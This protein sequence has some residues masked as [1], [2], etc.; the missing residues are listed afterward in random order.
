MATTVGNYPANS[1]STPQDGDPLSASVVVNHFNSTR[2][3]HTSHDADPGIHL[4]SSTLASRPAASTAGRKWLTADAGEYKLWYDD[5]VKWHEVGGAVI[6]LEYIASGA[7][8]KGD[9]LKLSGWN[10]GLDLPILTPATAASDVVFAIATGN[11]ANGASGYAINTG[12]IEDVN[13]SAFTVGDRLYPSGTS[14]PGSISSWFTTTKP[15]SGE[16]QMCAYVIRDNP[17]NGVLFV[18][19]SASAIVESSTNVAN[20]VVRRDGSGNFAA[21]T[22]TANLIGNVTGNVTGSAGSAASLTTPRTLWGQSFNGTANV[23]GAISGATSISATGN[24]TVGGALT[25]TG[26]NVSIN[27]VPYAFPSSAGTSGYVLKTDGAGNLTWDSVAVGAIA[28]NDLSDVT[29]TGN[30]VLQNTGSGWANANYV[31]F[32]LST[33]AECS[34]GPY[35]ALSGSSGAG[36]GSGLQK[37][38]TLG[39]V[40]LGSGSTSDVTLNGVFSVIGSNCSASG[41]LSVTGALSKGSGSF[42]IRHP[43]PELEETHDLVHSFIEGPYCDLIYRGTVDL[44]GGSA[45]VNIDKHFGMTEGT[46][47]ALNRN[48]QIFLQNETGWEPVRG[49]VAGNILSIGCRDGSSKDTVSWMVVGERRDANIKG[50]SWTD[51]DGR[52]IL[53]PVRPAPPEESE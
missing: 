41:D 40:V 24:V 6:E 45:R 39:T 4:Q 34:I 21:G 52:P 5:G 15:S 50:A 23:S 27:S 33:S 19:F 47:E 1:V 37:Q 32:G 13:T 3:A 35:I 36:I 10:N 42:K 22:V 7:I 28:L 12:F 16:Y 31:A 44:V 25:V 46:F 30:G 17:N 20:N 8:V 38:N 14:G 26:A 9:V 43:L 48:V 11:V 18:E 29:I 51:E 53:E 49:G 2:S